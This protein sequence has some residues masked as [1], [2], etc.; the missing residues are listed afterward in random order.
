MMAST[1]III[2]LEMRK[3]QCPS[4]P[5]VLLCPGF[6][7]RVLNNIFDTIEEGSMCNGEELNGGIC[8]THFSL[9]FSFFFSWRDSALYHCRM[10]MN[11]T[12]RCLTR[13]V[14]VEKQSLVLCYL[15]T[16]VCSSAAISQVALIIVAFVFKDNQ[17]LRWRLEIPQ[18]N[19]L[20]L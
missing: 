15:D 19:M 3:R 17:V 13:L 12:T 1:K 5:H 16:K 2:Y 7:Y 6:P 4:V 8:F 14:M 10:K 20:C 18:T 9:L 11:L